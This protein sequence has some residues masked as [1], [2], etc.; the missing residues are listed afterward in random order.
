MLTVAFSSFFNAAQSA[1]G[2][3]DSQSDFDGM[4][5]RH[6]WDLPIYEK[7]VLILICP[8]GID[9][10]RIR[11]KSDGGMRPL[12]SLQRGTATN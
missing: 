10:S 11:S 12:Y 4:L 5:Y 7:N 1:C 6:H 2:A 9:L 8:I 3:L